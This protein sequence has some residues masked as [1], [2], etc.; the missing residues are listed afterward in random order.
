MVLFFAI[1]DTKLGMLNH[2]T[3]IE[4]INKSWLEKQ[5]LGT[6]FIIWPMP[7]ELL[8]QHSPKQMQQWSLDMANTL[9]NKTIDIDDLKAW[10]ISFQQSNGLLADGIIGSE[11]QMALSLNAYNGPTLK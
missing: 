3:E 9:A 8:Q 10:I 1:Q 2:S 7:A 5:W 6:Y 11:T 4:F